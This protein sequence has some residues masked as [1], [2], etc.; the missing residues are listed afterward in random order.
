MASGVLYI[1]GKPLKLRCP[2]WARVT[3][4]DIFNTS[5][6]QKKGQESNCQFDSQP[7]KFGN[8]PDFLACRWCATY[9]WK[10]LNESYNFALNLI[11]I[12]SLHAKLWRPKVAGVPT[13][14]ILKLP[15]GSPRTKSH[16][17]V[18]PVERCRVYYKGG[19]WWLP[20]SAGH[21]ESCE[22]KLLMARSNTKSAPTTH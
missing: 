11:S 1:I 14:A 5:Y 22:S 2:K 12:G 16:L 18:G 8:P 19:R 13:L 21:D 20:P 4:L 7:L 6:G 15:L 17:D 10:A 3:H 9:H